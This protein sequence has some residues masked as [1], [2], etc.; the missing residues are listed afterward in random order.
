MTIGASDT[1]IPVHFAVANNPDLVVPHQGAAGFTLRD[2]F[3]VPDL[4]T[5]NDDIVNG[6]S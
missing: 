4:T 5:T 2:V 1:P 6:V 3:D